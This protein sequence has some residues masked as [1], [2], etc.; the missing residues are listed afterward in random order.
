MNTGRTDQLLLTTFLMFACNRVCTADPVMTAVPLTQAQIDSGKILFQGN[1]A[2]CHGK[3][4]QGEEF[5]PALKGT[6]FS[7]R[8]GG[9]PVS[10]LFE[11]LRQNMPPGGAGQIGSEAYASLVAF[12]LSTNGLKATGRELPDRAENLTTFRIPAGEA[13]DNS[14]PLP[15]SAG[16]LSAD[17]KLPVWPK[18][19][20][21]LASYTPITEDTLNA[22]ADGDWLTW[23][24]THEAWGFSPLKQINKGNVATLQLAWSLALSSG[25]NEIEPLVHDG[26]LFVFSYGDQVQAL[27][28]T[29]GSELW[30]Y[31]RQLPSGVAPTTKRNMALYDN[32]LYIGT[33]DVHEIALDVRSGAVVWDRALGDPGRSF[34]L[35]G[36]PLVA[37]G[38]VMQ[39]VI[40]PHEDQGGSGYLV[41]LDAETGRQLWRFNTVAGPRSP[42][43]DSWNGI[44]FEKRQG[45]S[46]WTS[47]SYDQTSNL[48]FFGPGNSYDTAPL[49]DPVHA[50]GITNDALYTDTTIALDPVSGKLKWYFQHMR[51]DQWDLDWAFE[52]QI[53]QLPIQGRP[54]KLVVTTGKVGIIDVLDANTGK[55]VYSFDMGL[56]TLISA[57]DPVSG[58]KTVRQELLPTRAHGVT[59]CPHVG[60]G[61]NWM[62]TS[63]NPSRK[64]LYV[65]ASETCMDLFPA[66]EGEHGFLSTGVNITLRPRSDSDGRFGR[67]QAISLEKRKTVWVNRQRPVYSGGVLSTAGDVVF[68]STADRWFGAYSATN[69]RVLWRAR[70]SDLPDAPPITYRADGRQYVVIVAGHGGSTSSILTALTPESPLPVASATSIW[71][72]TLPGSFHSAAP[73]PPSK[74]AQ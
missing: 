71:A 56:Q 32:L 8:W 74:R 25:T 24:R 72:F 62:P 54:R 29:T 51:N 58:Q 36:G 59:V 30:H 2:S 57:I 13:A 64:T 44:E 3:E 68:A 43:G 49:R 69:G 55:Y 70:L 67:L 33:S 26:V 38:V 15:K 4:L 22:P 16:P 40:A 39:G 19:R 1:C 18:S 52:R 42:G 28:A 23:R 12:L 11:Y 34:G 46:I 48:V 7:E 61:R 35:T 63:Y 66:G 6:H 14:S 21:P 31:R 60:G 20:D 17:V 53:I 47:G 41:A 73:T 65:A 10:E 27:D 50:P 37:K 45:S 5:G 9:R